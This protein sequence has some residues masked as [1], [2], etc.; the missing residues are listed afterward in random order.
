M[1]STV[2]IVVIII[3]VYPQTSSVKYRFTVL[4]LKYRLSAKTACDAGVT[5]SLGE[6][7]TW[8]A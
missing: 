7:G 2:L 6:N 4:N 5:R 8:Q 1:A 3:G